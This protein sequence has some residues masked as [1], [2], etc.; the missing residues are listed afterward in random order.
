MFRQVE[1]IGTGSG[2]YT[3]SFASD[4]PFS[5]MD[6][7]DANGTWTLDFNTGSGGLGVGLGSLS[8]WSIT[9]DIEIS[10][11][12][13]A[14]WSTSGGVS[15]VNSLNPEICQ[16]GTYTVTLDNGVAGCP[17]SEEQITITDNCGGY[18]PTGYFN[19]DIDIVEELLI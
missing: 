17:T 16:A 11:P 14:T 13:N 8:G 18:Y 10:Q 19:F 2:S 4:D 1:S 9:F 6:G 12:V 3:G 7:C 5:N 15:D